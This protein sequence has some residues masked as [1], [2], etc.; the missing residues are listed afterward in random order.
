VAALGLAPLLADEALSSKRGLEAVKKVMPG[1]PP[2]T[3]K[4]MR[5]NLTKA[6]G[7]YGSIV[8]IGGL[9]P[10]SAMALNR[11]LSGKKKKER[12]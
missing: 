4:V 8:G 11:A 3:L 5:K 9:V 10:L 2:E 1:L 7:T 12:R 6:F